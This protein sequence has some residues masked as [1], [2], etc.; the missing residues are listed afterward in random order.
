MDPKAGAVPSADSAPCRSETYLQP[1]GVADDRLCGKSGRDWTHGPGRPVF[2]RC[3]RNRG[4]IPDPGGICRICA[5][6]GYRAG[7]GKI[8]RKVE[9]RCLTVWLLE[10]ELPV[11]WRQENWRRQGKKC[12]CWSKETISGE[13]AMTRRMNMEF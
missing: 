3:K 13:T 10:Q 8:W 7:T 12:W 9:K 5:V 4:K 11:V 6:Y 2:Y 1:C